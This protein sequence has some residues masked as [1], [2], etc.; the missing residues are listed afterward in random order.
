MPDFRDIARAQLKIDEG[1]KQYP[2][3]DSV[4]KLTIGCGRNLVDVGLRPREIDFLLDNDI[5]EAVACARHLVPTFD[6]LSEARKAVLVNMAFNLGYARLSGFL[7]M[8]Q[9]VR[10][11]RF[12]DAAHE[13]R[14]SDW[15]VQVGPRAERLAKI[16]EGSA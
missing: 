9:A 12:A 10:D 13:M 16:M 7:R 5:D 3:T 1:V 11:G 15:A 2:Y 8:L 4:G 14:D 6:A